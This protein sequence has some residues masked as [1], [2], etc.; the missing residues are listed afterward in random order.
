MSQSATNTSLL[1][2]DF[3]PLAEDGSIQSFK[4]FIAEQSQRLNDSFDPQQRCEQQVYGRA[5]MIDGVLQAI[6]DKFCAEHK[7]GIS[8]IA[9][10]GY[11]R[12]E[13]H[14]ASDVDILILL[15][16]DDDTPYQ[17]ALQSLV[18]FL[19][20]IG[21]DIGSSVRSL[22]DCTREAGKDITVA[23]NLM[24]ARHL[25]G[26]D[27]LL[28][29]MQK[30]IGPNKIWPVKEFFLAKREE[31]EQRYG[32]FQNSGYKVE[33]NLKESPGGLRDIQIIEWVAKRYFDADGMAGLK[34][35]GF[36]TEDEYQSLMDAREYLWR[37]RWALHTLVGRSENRLQ[38][39]KQVKLA[40]QFGYKEKNNRPAVEHFMQ[41]YY[42][43]V[44]L[45]ERVSEMLLQLFNENIVQAEEDATPI[46]INAR[47][48]I[49]RGYIE[50]TH[51][52]IY[53][54]RPLALLE[55]FYLIQQRPEIKGVRANTIRLIRKYRE[56][57][58][59]KFR[60]DIRVRSLFMDMLRQPRGITHEFRRMNRYG[61]LARY[62]PAFRGIVGQM[63]FDMFHAYTVDEHTLMVLRNLRR[64]SVPEFEHELPYVSEITKRIPKPELLYL[65]GIFHDIG[66]G[67][68]GDHSELG[69]VDAREF[70]ELHGLSE[71]DT[72]LVA[73]LVDSHLLMSM[74]A[75]RKDIS[76]PD[77][78]NDFA[79][80]MGTREHLD[81]LFLLTTADIR[82]TNP[83]LWNGWRQSL[84]FELHKQTARAL[85]Q[86][87]A[88]KLSESQ[89]I[90]E[91]QNHALY[92]LSKNGFPAERAERIWETHHSEYFLRNTSWEIY[93]HTQVI[94]N[95]GKEHLPIVAVKE[96]FERG[97]STVM[98]YTHDRDY[99][100][101]HICAS[102]DQLNLNILDAR[103][104]DT[105]DGM[106]VCSY[107]VVEDNGNGVET[108]ERELEIV[109]SMRDAL[110]QDAS[111][112]I[113]VNRHAPRQLK[114]FNTQTEVSFQQD[115]RNNRT[116]LT[117]LS[118][119]RP[120]LLSKVGYVFQKYGIVIQN[121][122]IGTVGERA[123]DVFFI[124]D[125]D[126]NP[127]TDLDLQEQLR[128]ALT[129]ELDAHQSAA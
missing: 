68:G 28:A 23:T 106:S 41:M 101:G 21:L 103:I 107:V 111:C 105:A 71:E 20:D 113:P 77:V 81:Y 4:A 54:E 66:K 127:I 118:A 90:E 5:A 123:E 11:G 1:D 3:S 108:I 89:L 95:A 48:Q 119:D 80:K 79:E 51:E 47:Y 100:F 99:L 59:D 64:V 122:K 61:I 8:L 125:K 42:R 22:Q 76:D 129:E 126:R 97:G 121:A 14:P 15:K 98:V 35:Q 63:Q 58:D 46:P 56:L 36:L 9:V 18:T 55:I 50:A 115:S 7:A 10:G 17:E 112:P 72:S 87:L 13:L 70:C 43:T 78:V 85:E 124:T 24:E 83:E 120:G 45:V 128:L 91:A 65:A 39:D 26:D 96:V 37:V 60:N 94:A 69:A 32:R 16:E 53:L 84:L 31:Q 104:H 29:E 93:W 114:I 27:C 92:L 73:W 62:I 74:T 67:R 57:I 75:Q 88:N 109:A 2:F 40:E 116:A 110:A 102:L 19:W 52:N 33:P 117:L 12:G 82:G 30:A 25:A 38:F 86:G 6:W 44:M 49:V 34:L